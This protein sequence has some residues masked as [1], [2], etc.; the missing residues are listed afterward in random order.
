MG[1]G[2]P[3]NPSGAL[4]EEEHHLFLPRVEGRSLECTENSVVRSAGQCEERCGRPL[5]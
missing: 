1:L 3:Q 4:M 2:G 5:A